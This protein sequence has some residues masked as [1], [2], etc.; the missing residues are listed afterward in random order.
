MKFSR[1]YCFNIIQTECISLLFT[2]AGC[3]HIIYN[4]MDADDS[5]EFVVFSENGNY[6]QCVFVEIFYSFKNGFIHIKTHSVLSCYIYY[7]GINIF[8]QNRYFCF[9]FFK[10]E[11]SLCINGAADSGN[12]LKRRIG[13]AFEFCI[14]ISRN[15]RVGIRIFVSWYVNFL[16]NPPALSWSWL[17]L[18][19]FFG[20][21]QV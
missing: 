9:C 18:R 10:Y 12:I 11:F 1:D 15:G 14:T 19:V 20:L 17:I 16:H 3:H 5:A 6:A 13:F 8:Q 2:F 4:F 7:A 21:N